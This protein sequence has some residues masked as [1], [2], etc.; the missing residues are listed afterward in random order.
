MP[1]F[2]ADAVVPSG[3][4][5]RL[6]GQ[7]PS[8]QSAATGRNIQRLQQANSED[9]AHAGKYLPGVHAFF[10]VPLPGPDDHFTP[11][12]KLLQDIINLIRSN[13]PVPSHPPVV[14]D[15]TPRALA[16][17][18]EWLSSFGFDLEKGLLANQHTT[19]GFGVE[20]RDPSLLRRLFRDHPFAEFF[21]QVIT[22]GMDY[23]VTSEL[24]DEDRQLEAS[25]IFV[26]GNHK[27]ATDDTPLVT[28]LLYR[29]VTHGFAIPVQA[30]RILQL[31]GVQVQPCGVVSQFTLAPDGSRKLKKRLT[32]DLSFSSGD[33]DLS[34]NS[35]IDASAYPPLV[36]GW[37]LSRVLHFIVALRLAFPTESILMTKYDFSDAYRRMAH[38]PSA[39]AQSVLVV[40]SVAYITLRLTFGGAPN[41]AAWCSYSEMIADLAHELFLSPS[42]SPSTLHSPVHPTVPPP[43]RRFATSPSQARPLAVEI[44]V[45]LPFRVD[46][47]IDD[48]ICIFVD[49]PDVVDRAAHAVPLCVHA[50]CRPHAD[51]AE[52]IPRKP[53]LHPDKLQAEGTPDVVQTILGWVV[54][55]HHLLIKLP[56]DKFKAWT[57][58]ID[59][60]LLDSCCSFS[61]LESLV[62]RLNHAAMILP[63][64]RHFLHRLRAPLVPRQYS[65]RNIRL[66]FQQLQ[67]LRL[68]RDVL[69]HANHGVKLNCLTHRR[70]TAIAWADSCPFGLG[71]YGSSGF[72]WRLRIPPTS[73]L[74]G[75]DIANNALEFLALVVSVWLS[76][77]HAADPE[78]CILVL[79]D[80]TSA[81]GWAHRSSRPP[82]T[83]PYY[84]TV[85]LLAR[86]LCRLVT[87]SPHCLASQHLPGP[88]NVVADLLSFS[89]SCREAPHPLAP[90]DPSDAVLTDR[91]HRF[92]PQL[93]PRTFAISPL[94]SEILSFATLAL[95]TLESSLIRKPSPRTSPGTESGG[96][97]SGSALPPDS[98][99]TPSSLTYPDRTS[100]SSSEPFLKPTGLPVGHLQAELL[101]NVQE[102][103]WQQLSA[104]PQATWLRRFGVVSNRAPVTSRTAP[105]FSPASASSSVPTTTGTP[106]RTDNAPSPRNSSA[107]FS[108]TANQVPPT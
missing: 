53:L 21:L 75:N 102:S 8:K 56:D 57:S 7:G 48:M 81:L 31:K 25:K 52:P 55:S 1:P 24:S 73:P 105:S 18:T 99:I 90:D 11:D 94:P 101:D 98:S 65:H 40:S 61:S 95:R 47:F 34:V 92:L 17:N 93:I 38:S 23:H 107:A 39:A 4:E 29:E 88:S 74:H 36:Y 108:P 15:T 3:R 83:S 80:N 63:L 104:L 84:A 43:N 64:T 85:Q 54:D 87:E 67:D 14:L 76:L 66:D 6:E 59:Q 70:P 103:W 91:F 62:G 68:W 96:A 13:P 50:T 106:H 33:Q 26:R 10:C 77:L 45:T 16:A 49:R 79:G 51:E 12:D 42:W 69:R 9:A 82:P 78:S 41:P 60:L 37:C 19:F 89:G 20:F 5:R 30:S 2:G 27:S 72:A 35:R 46:T 71:G 28:K 58:D 100:T 97:G 32:H 44:P 86:K 22:H